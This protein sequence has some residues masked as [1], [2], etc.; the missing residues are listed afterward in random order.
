M[1][2]AKII[3]LSRLVGGGGGS[4][5]GGSEPEVVIINRSGGTEHIGYVRQKMTDSLDNNIPT[6]FYLKQ[7]KGI[8]LVSSINREGGQIYFSVVTFDASLSN[9][10]VMTTLYMITDSN[11]I[12][13][14]I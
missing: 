2:I 11:T 12:E 7:T 9:Q 14:V 6:I 13:P 3:A 10:T 5:S 8:Y 4:G 1:S